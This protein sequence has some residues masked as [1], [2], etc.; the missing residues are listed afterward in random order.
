MTG[1]SIS[2][3]ESQRFTGGVKGSGLRGSG[4]GCWKFDWT[5]DGPKA[6]SCEHVIQKPAKLRA[7]VCW[8]NVTRH[9]CGEAFF[10]RFFAQVL[11]VGSFCN[12]CIL[13]AQAALCKFICTRFCEQAS[14]G[15][16]YVPASLCKGRCASFICTF[17][18]ARVSLCKFSLFRD[19]V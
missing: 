15:K 16:F 9:D 14:Q 12:P 1:T 18:P 6:L 7:S 4:R 19:I 11:C 5:R 8:Q 3:R 2:S 10:A 17:F 13:S